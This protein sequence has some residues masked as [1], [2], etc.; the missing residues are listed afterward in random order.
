MENKVL[1]SIED[2][3][4]IINKYETYHYD[5]SLTTITLRFNKKDVYKN[6]KKSRILDTEQCR[7]H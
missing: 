7:P 3:I 6:E 5:E 1:L 4:E 2:Y